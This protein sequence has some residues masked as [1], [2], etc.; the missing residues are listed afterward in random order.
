M[1]T[2]RQ[3][4]VGRVRTIQTHLSRRQA[5]ALAASVVFHL[6]VIGALVAGL[7]SFIAP[8]E[9]PAIQ[10]IMAP[11]SWLHTTPPAPHVQAPGHQPPSKAPPQILQ[12]P[13]PP[14]PPPVTSDDARAR[15]FGAPFVGR[16]SVREALQTAVTCAHADLSHLSPGDQERC[17]NLNRQRTHEGP[18]YAVGPSDP[19]KRAALDQAARNN[20]TWSS[21][22]ASRRMDDFPSL[23]ALAG[24]TEPPPR[25]VIRRD[26]T[27][28]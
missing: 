3:T 13:K 18:A 10:V 27:Q 8:R 23:R 12:L 21:Y 25:P 17:R 15:L 5:A 22:R 24:R 16:D 14:A 6:A 7:G 28:N 19:V 26:P 2:V 9:E 4:L 11:E 1:R 20:E